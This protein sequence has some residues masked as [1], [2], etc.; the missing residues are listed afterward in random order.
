MLS[1]LQGL[2]IP[3]ADFRLLNPSLCSICLFN[4]SYH[5]KQSLILEHLRLNR[6]SGTPSNE[7]LKHNGS[8]GFCSTWHMKWSK[9]RT[10]YGVF[11][12]FWE[13]DLKY[14]S[15]LS[16]NTTYRC[17]HVL[18]MDGDYFYNKPNLSWGRRTEFKGSVNECF[19]SLIL[20]AV[21]SLKFT[22]WFFLFILSDSSNCC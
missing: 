14:L 19:R 20:W 18:N 15:F 1:N 5:A 6:R 7:I 13:F 10:P 4:S 8:L 2:F 11:R 21:V 12:S 3:K 17:C 22:T 16:F 9:F